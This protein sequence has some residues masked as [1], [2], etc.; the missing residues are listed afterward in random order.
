MS[1]GAGRM[2]NVSSDNICKI[3]LPDI[4]EFCIV[5]IEDQVLVAALKWHAAKGRNTTYARA[6]IGDGA[7]I[8][9]HHLLMGTPIRGYVVDH[10][11]ENGLNNRRS[12]LRVITHGDNIRRA[13]KT[14]GVSFLKRLKA[15][16]WKAE[17]KID[18]ERYHVGY[19]ATEEEAIAARNS[20]LVERGKEVSGLDK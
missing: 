7:Y 4:D 6:Y 18:G 2:D 15:R 19:F 20:F 1:R 17:V 14:S 3:A 9:M 8:Y 10:I 12:N 5:D 11:D 16:P 13:S